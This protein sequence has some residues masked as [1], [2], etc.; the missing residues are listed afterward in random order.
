M[1]QNLAN[2]ETYVG[3]KPKTSIR[4]TSVAP[5]LLV[6]W[7]IGMIDKIGVAVVATNRNFLSEMHL[8]G[9]N[10][11]I[12]SL[13]SALLFSYG[14]G[15]FVWG[16]LVDKFG[17][18]RCAI[19]GLSLWA[20]STLLAAVTPNFQLLFISRIV[21]GFS[22]AF[23][24]P[25]SNSLTARWFPTHERGRAK[26]IWVNGTNIG[27]AISGFVVTLLIHQFQWRGV[28][29]FLTVFA[30]LVC[31]PMIVFLIKD[32][33]RDDKRVSSVELE[34]IQQLHEAIVNHS[35]EPRRNAWSF[36]LVI[37]SFTATIYGVFGLGTWFPTYLAVAKHISPAAASGYILLAWALGIPTMFIA[38]RMTDKTHKKAIWNVWAF[39][40][41]GILLFLAGG[42]SSPIIS[43]LLVA[44][45]I[46]LVNGVTTFIAHSLL[47]SMSTVDRMGKDAGIMTG[48]SNI[49]GAFGPAVMGALISL[50]KGQ[51]SYAFAFLIVSFFVGAVCSFVLKRQGY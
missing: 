46:C 19:W 50:G 13:V 47:H 32:N 22:E 44:L 38:G 16:W 20:L 24:W 31:I 36:P 4:W 33:P 34:H 12:G 18:K 10:A 9:N 45:A 37:I 39:I 17:P 14:I 26:S 51:Y 30:A 15:F 23:L 28:F 43:V 25:V 21:L 49:L 11:L 1:N 7:I 35:L 8:M 40:A 2:A 3:P 27:P 42:M 48:V 5:T 29:W 41:C 6:I